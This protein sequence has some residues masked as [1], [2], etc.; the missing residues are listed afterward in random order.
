MLMFTL[1]AAYQIKQIEQ[2]LSASGVPQCGADH[3]QWLTL[4][5]HLILFLDY[6]LA[7]ERAHPHAT[8]HV[9]NALQM[10][11]MYTNGQGK[12]CLTVSI[13]TSHTVN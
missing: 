6:H 5:A 12:S 8:T 10:T 3:S 7:H 13:D 4:E 2:Q 11:K 1:E 9:L